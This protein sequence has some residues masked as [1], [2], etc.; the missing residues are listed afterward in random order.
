[1]KRKLLL[2]GIMSAILFGS[3]GQAH[4]SAC[5]NVKDKIDRVYGIG[6][7]DICVGLNTE[8]DLE[9]NPYVYLSP[10]LGC[11]TGL[12]LP[13]LPDFGLSMGSIDWCDIAQAITGPYVRASNKKMRDAVQETTDMIESGAQ[14]IIDK[15]LEKVPEDVRNHI[16]SDI[17][18]VTP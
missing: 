10:D 4:A 7:R 14:D 3:M 8:A 12:Q 9:N 1:M 11:P 17:L 18:T 15:G 6:N 5:Q 16:D 2:T 13:G